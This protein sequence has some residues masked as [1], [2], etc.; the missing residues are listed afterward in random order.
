MD[1]TP[2]IFSLC[3]LIQDSSRSLSNPSITWQRRL[4]I[5]PGDHADVKTEVISA[6][7]KEIIGDQSGTFI[8]FFDRKKMTKINMA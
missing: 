2:G 7:N 4:F 6:T 1:G 8:L 3:S 5:E